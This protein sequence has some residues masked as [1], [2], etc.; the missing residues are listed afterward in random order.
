MPPKHR[1]KDAKKPDTPTASQSGDLSDR[2]LKELKSNGKGKKPPKPPHRSGKGKASGSGGNAALALA[3]SVAAVAVAASAGAMP[4]RPMA[5]D[6]PRA[7]RACTKAS[8]ACGGTEKG[9]GRRKFLPRILYARMVE[10]RVTFAVR[11]V[12]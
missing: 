7:E 6:T 4:S 10:C 9:N 12:G 8:S 11:A 2:E 3:V 1:A 5:G